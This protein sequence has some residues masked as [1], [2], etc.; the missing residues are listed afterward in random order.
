MI[1]YE[2]RLDDG[3]EVRF[4]VDPRRTLPLVPA[5]R[6]PEWTRLSYH[7]CSDCP[8]RREDHERCPPAL[9]V[10]DIMT[11]FSSV[12]SHAQAE[13]TV[14]TPSRNIHRR[15]DV[16]T[17]LHSLLGL[18]MA[19]S[20][21]PVLSELRPMAH[22]HLPFA[23]NEETAFRAAS[24]WLLRQYFLAQR[25]GEANFSLDGLKALYQRLQ[26]VNRSFTE[27]VRAAADK[28]AN[29][30]AVVLLFSLSVLVSF[31]LEDDLAPLRDLYG[32]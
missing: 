18:V 30:N 9:D 15:V 3:S 32:M 23:T 5:E 20:G 26:E 16:Q 13:V 12:L 10:A 24:F 11:R 27:R 22:L 28:D 6:A 31:T 17:A 1:E 21:C 14:R 2:F 29:L 8:L 4:S 19:T 25:G 7:Q